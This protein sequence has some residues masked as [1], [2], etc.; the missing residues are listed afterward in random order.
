MNGPIV[1]ALFTPGAKPVP[2]FT[3][4]QT[5]PL[6]PKEITVILVV[7]LLTNAWKTP[8]FVGVN[9]GVGVGVLVLVGVKVGV[10]VGVTGISL[11]VGVIVGVTEEVGVGV[12]QLT[13]ESITPFTMFTS[14]KFGV[15]NSIL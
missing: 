10:G 12:V 11:D 6:N 9:V 1:K 13:N 4:C 3:F 7:W 14:E 2:P 15:V 5:A 8:V